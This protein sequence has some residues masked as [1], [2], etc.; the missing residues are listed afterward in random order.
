[1]KKTTFGV[2]VS[3]RGFFPASLAE[4]GRRQFLARLDALGYGAVIL[5]E[6]AT[7]H[8]AVETLEDAEKYARLFRE[9]A[10]IVDGVVVVLPN[11]GDELGVAETLSRARLGV[12]VL[13]QAC[14]DTMAR[15]DLAHRRDAF[16]GKLS[17]CNNLRQRGIPFSNTRLHTCAIDSEEFTADLAA[18]AGVCRVAR[19]LARARIGM[20]GQRPNAFNTVRYSEKLLERSGIHICAVD[21]SEILAGAQAMADTPAVDAK[22]TAIRA[23]GPL[24][25]GTG[26]EALRKQAKLI[27][28]IE[29]WIAAN[30]CD[31][32]AIQCWASVQQ[33]YGCATC[34][35][36]SMMGESGKP[37][38]CEV[39]I[40]GALSMFALRLASGNVPGFLDWNNNFDADRDKCVC[41]HCSNY[42]KSFMGEIREIGALDILGA[43]LGPEKCFGAVKGRV[44]A[45]PM[46]FAKI[47]TDDERGRIR[48]YIGEGEFTNDVVDTAGG[49]AVC[50][51]TGLQKLLD[52]L[53]RQGYEHHV[54][55]VRGRVAGVLAEACATYLGWDVHVHGD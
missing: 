53:C 48:M 10:D 24:A 16:C 54:A 37:S 11:F 26:V 50:R 23:Y 7:P 32:S 22:I 17:V 40:M 15:M 39:D 38:A 18:F 13:V 45:G 49:V 55:M 29:Q 30:H 33:N 25:A 5:P 34:L 41:T 31:A 21:L 44:Q 9:Q 8:G 20:I 43:S 42:P 47:S 36:M 52:Y 3:T 12:P 1:M 46:T 6:T 4:E 2:V 27:L 35:G 28:T 51:V 19:G 14:D